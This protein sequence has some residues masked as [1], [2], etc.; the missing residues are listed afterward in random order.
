M[1]LLKYQFLAPIKEV[2][3]RLDVEE[4]PFSVDLLKYKSR[5]GIKEPMLSVG[6]VLNRKKTSCLCYIHECKTSLR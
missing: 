6:T 3:P 5:M 1:G 4:E 2:I